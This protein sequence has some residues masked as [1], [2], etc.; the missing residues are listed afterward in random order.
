M[1]VVGVRVRSHAVQPAE[2]GN[3]CPECRPERRRGPSP[4]SA[5][6]VTSRSW[7]LC[8]RRDRSS[9]TS[10][11]RPRTR[12][13]YAISGPTPGRRPG[14]HRLGV[15]RGRPRRRDAVG[16]G[17]SEPRRPQ[18][19][20][21]EL[22][23]SPFTSVAAAAAAPA[24]AGRA[25]ARRRRGRGRAGPSRRSRAGRR[26]PTTRRALGLETVAGDGDQRAGWRDQGDVGAVGGGEPD[27]DPRGVDQ[28]GPSARYRRT[29]G[30]ATSPSRLSSTGVDPNEADPGVEVS[31][32]GCPVWAS[33]AAGRRARL[34]PSVSPRAGRSTAGSRARRPSS[35]FGPGPAWSLTRARRRAGG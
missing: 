15:G 5:S 1:E 19:A 34:T 14:G 35:S 17:Q 4:G 3:R 18:R 25:S 11:R 24:G 7:R 20:G 13:S 32:S 22:A 9:Q 28:R 21:A 27:R 10:R 6:T 12:S 23:G 33:S 8:H 2:L 26:R 31:V 30:R 16:P 29:A